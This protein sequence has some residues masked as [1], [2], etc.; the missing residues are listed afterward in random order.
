MARPPGPRPLGGGV[1]NADA[2]A[3]TTN[4]NAALSAS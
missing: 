2:A 1:V 4:A 3:S